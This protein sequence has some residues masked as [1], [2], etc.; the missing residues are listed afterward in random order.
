MPLAVAHP[1]TVQLP[2]W[3]G[4]LDVLLRLIEKS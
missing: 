2:D 4:P 1:Y 3:A